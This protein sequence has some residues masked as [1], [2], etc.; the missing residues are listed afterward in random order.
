MHLKSLK[1]KHKTGRCEIYCIIE[2]KNQGVIFRR[3]SNKEINI[4]CMK[5]I[6]ECIQSKTVEYAEYYQPKILLDILNVLM[7]IYVEGENNLSH[8]MNSK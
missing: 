8:A 3:G 1:T 2:R 6:S 5:Y 7:K 4:W